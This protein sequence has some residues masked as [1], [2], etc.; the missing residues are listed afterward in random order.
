MLSTELEARNKKLFDA[1]VPSEGPAAT[2]EGEFLRAVNKIVY[3][4]FNDG[5]YW[6][7][8]YGCETCGPAAAF[9]MDV[10]PPLYGVQE[11]LY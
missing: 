9:L 4:Y 7:C 10:C 11:A 5:D 1:L 8:G 2:L 3:R 6:Y